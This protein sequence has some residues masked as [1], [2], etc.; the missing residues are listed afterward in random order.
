[1]KDNRDLLADAIAEEG[2]PKLCLRHPRPVTFDSRE[3]P[4]CQIEEE[5]LRLTDEKETR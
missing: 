5:F 3:C 4:V 1:M 2:L